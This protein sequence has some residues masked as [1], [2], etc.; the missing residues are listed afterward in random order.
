M[1]VNNNQISGRQTARLLLFQMLG[2]SALLIPPEL[3]KTAGTDGIFSIAAGVF[4]GFVYLHFLKRMGMN[5]QKSYSR[6][7][8]DVFGT[9][10]GNVIKGIYVL[11]FLLLA[12]RVISIFAELV[13]KELLEETFTFVLAVLIGLLYYGISGGIEGIARIFEILFWLVL[14][15]LFLMM[16][17]AVPGVDTDYWLPVLQ[18]SPF[19]VLKGSYQVFFGVSIL[20]LV[21]FFAEYV[22]GQVYHCA[23]RAL[24]WT[25]CILGVLYLILLGMFGDQALA[26]LDYPAV[27]M[28]SRIQ[29]T[30]GFFKRTDAMMFGVWFFTLYALAGGLLFFAGQLAAVGKTHRQLWLSAEMAVVYLLAYVFY[31]S[32]EFQMICEKIFSYVGTPF[33]VLVPLIVSFLLGGCGKQELEKKEF[34]VLLTVSSDVD[35][36]EQWLNGMQEGTKTVDY[37]HLKVLLLE[38]EF[39]EETDRMAE[40]LELLKE[41]KNVPFNT[42]I[43]AAENVKEL[44][45]AE[46]G[47]EMSLGDYLE[48]LLERE[49]TVKKETYPTLG[50]LYQ[51]KEN[52]KETLFIPTVS[53]VKEKPAITSYEV[54]RRGTAIG[55]TESDV[56]CL[57]FFVNNQM[58]AYVVNLGVHNYVRLSHSRNNIL[59]KNQRAV[60]GLLK[61]QIVAEIVC[62]G[63]VLK[64]SAGDDAVAAEEWLQTQIADYMTAKARLA[65]ENGID[66]TNSFKKLGTE[67]DWYVYYM[68]APD[69]FESEIEI[70]F[71]VKI[72]WID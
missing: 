43:V 46:E 18:Q 13:V 26:A 41:E 68:Q 71:Q 7:L 66:V 44:T 20:C 2:Y 31:N 22:N 57:S 48:Q 24:I 23:R 37:N 42:Y 8:T 27:T 58:D 29:M 70:V 51:E 36:T 61:R 54:Y 1:F 39:L 21:P 19:C 35:F 53:L 63:V 33:V 56:A 47:L 50:M 64:S 52:R 65:L 25:G 17:L 69:F 40:M 60:T 9:V 11:Y 45:E 30:G 16:L 59:L 34:P 15:P 6:T 49:D 5:M 14:I 32:E 10:F 67:R 3:A 38:R 28:M 4:F 62:D 12:A 72:N 55:Q